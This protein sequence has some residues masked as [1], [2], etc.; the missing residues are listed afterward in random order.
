MTDAK[1]MDVHEAL[2]EVRA[3][4][5]RLEEEIRTKTD[6]YN[7][8]RKAQNELVT[9]FQ[10]AKLQSEKQALELSAKSEELSTLNQLHQ[11]LKSSFQD[12]ESSVR[13]LNSAIEK[14]RHE[15]G[16]KVQKLEGEK[17]EL[18]VALDEA[19]ESSQSL[20]SQVNANNKEIEDLKRI[21]SLK[22]KKL[23]ET[24]DK[25][26][27]SKDLTQRDEVICQLEEKHRD[28]EDQ[29][30]W[31][32]EQFQHLE[33][34][35]ERLQG[36]FRTSKAEWESEKSLML[37]EISSLQTNLDSQTRISEN[38]QTQL[39]IC[40]Q[41]L[42]H[43]ES[44]RKLLEVEVSEYKS[45][46]ESIFSE[47]HEAKVAIEK[48]SHK[49]DEE[50]AELRDSLA[51]K[52]SQSKEMGYKMAHLEQE[53]HDL[54]ASL[55]EFR[56]S[57]ITNCGATGM[58]K[59]L[60]K[61]YQGLELLHK[62]CTE[63]LKDKEVEW[64]SQMEKVR[65]EMEEYLSELKVESEKV[66][67]L[68]EELESCR[69][70]SELQNEEIS[71]KIKLLV[72]SQNTQLETALEACKTENQSLVY[73]ANEQNGKIVD[74][75]QQLVL[76]E[77]L[78]TE[79]TE[80]IEAQKQENE[81]FFKII[82]D[83]ESSM[84]NL[85]IVSKQEKDTLLQVI[86]E[87]NERIEELRE[88]AK[89]LEKEITNA[90]KSSEE[91]QIQIDVIFQTLQKLEIEASDLHQ[92]L[93]LK[94][95]SLLQSS[96]HTEELEALLQIKKL[97]TEKLK[98]EFESIVKK[99][100]VENQGLH[101]DVR[102][103]SSDREHLMVEMETTLNLIGEFSKDD[104]LM[105]MLE[106]MLRKSNVKEGLY[107]PLPKGK[108]GMVDTRSPLV[109]LNKI[110]PSSF[111]KPNITMEFGQKSNLRNWNPWKELDV[112][113]IG[114]N[115]DHNK[116]LKL[117]KLKD[118]IKFIMQT[119]HHKTILPFHDYIHPQQTNNTYCSRPPTPL[120]ANTHTT[121]TP[122]HTNKK[123]D[124]K[125]LINGFTGVWDEDGFTRN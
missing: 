53:N 106:N 91:K 89:A 6:L 18:V 22:D 93:E 2:D 66:E 68:Q 31:K 33:E 59:K 1:T 30:K 29:L 23:L 101:E 36:N 70:L 123:Y 54:T 95:E 69:C 117:W 113:E 45:R 43:E 118:F 37:E 81:R 17:K 35:H 124:P 85:L 4:K 112:E 102:K 51:T 55:K 13:H 75:Q 34:A 7:N 15:Y 100:E 11:D 82:A 47:C 62:K 108:D 120:T 60:Q 79:R 77:T 27:T 103:V 88:D 10:E 111:R 19:T 119:K 125:S 16:E 40:N 58:L 56:E 97:E 63:N 115:F 72:E 46:F 41:A 5:E 32:N 96:K 83:K 99:L 86:E 12:K 8:L 80:S 87:R 104:G 90:L 67:Q 21:L 105:K 39:R 94:N 50:V 110:P 114:M 121:N 26:Q 65:N 74:L 9:K 122:R 64:K 3:Q 42:A 14:L 116:F 71:T 52:E 49:R 61:K 92:K 84:E 98:G 57:Q 20:K 73:K 78:V 48:L 38:L 24:S 107:S 44:T 76:L 109:D 28:V 25:A